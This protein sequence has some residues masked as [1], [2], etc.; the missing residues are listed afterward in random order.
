MTSSGR[1]SQRVAGEVERRCATVVIGQAILPESAPTLMRVTE[2]AAEAEGAGRVSQCAIAAT[3]L[4]TLRGS[5]Q[6]VM[7]A[8]ML[9]G[10]FATDVTGLATLPGSALRVMVDVMLVAVAMEEV[11]V[12]IWDE[13]A[14]VDMEIQGVS[15]VDAILAAEVVDP[16]ATSATGLVTLPGS[17]GRKRTVATSATALGTLRGTAARTR[18]P[19]TTAMRWV[20]L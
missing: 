5:A 3:G 1:T 4:V 17:A 15:E 2:G 11:D 13:V 16:S 6:R 10:Q 18:T 8:E 12:V 19:A 9:E 20:T 14:A 7:E